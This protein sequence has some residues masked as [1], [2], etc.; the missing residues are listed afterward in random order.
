VVEE[1]QP[2]VA[3]VPAR[4]TPA[5][6]KR[7]AADTPCVTSIRHHRFVVIDIVISCVNANLPWR[8]AAQELKPGTCGA[9]TP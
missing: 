8:V 3:E 5:V 7:D 9:L 1:V 2:L 6:S 4:C